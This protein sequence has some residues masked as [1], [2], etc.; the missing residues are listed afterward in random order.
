MTI[1]YEKAMEDD[2]LGPFFIDE[3][4]DDIKS[5][6]WVEHIE[7]LADFWLAKILGED[8]YYGNFVGAHVKMPHIKKESFA[9]WLELFS[10]TADEVYIGSVAEQFKKKGV[11]FSKQF[12][13]RTKN[14]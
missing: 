13:N 10:Q 8:T 7:L 12:L 2:I 3:I 14:I 5:E 1:F 6:D 9:R 4:G 11:Q